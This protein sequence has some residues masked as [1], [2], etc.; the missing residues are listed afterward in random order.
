[1]KT[2]R[3]FDNTNNILEINEVS[4][5]HIKTSRFFLNQKGCYKKIYSHT[6]NITPEYLETRKRCLQK[7]KEDQDWHTAVVLGLS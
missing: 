3:R 7:L 5:T 2:F 6:C 4:K 1:M